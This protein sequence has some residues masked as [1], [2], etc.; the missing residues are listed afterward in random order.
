MTVE[1]LFDAFGCI[2]ETY[3]EEAIRASK[4]S[5]AKG[6]NNDSM[7]NPTSYFGRFIITESRGHTA[8]MSS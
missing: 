5:S 2:D 4:K 8:S 3:V 7:D 6:V 1:N